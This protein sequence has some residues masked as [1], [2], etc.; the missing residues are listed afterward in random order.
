VQKMEGRRKKKFKKMGTESDRDQAEICGR[1]PAADCWSPTGLGPT[2]YGRWP[3]VAAGRL[4][5]D[6]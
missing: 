3:L 2:T 5:P 6:R 1:R 4:D